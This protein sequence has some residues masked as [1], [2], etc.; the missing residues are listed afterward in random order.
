M[1]L[2]PQ[3]TVRQ[4]L[5][6]TATVGVLVL[7]HSWLLAHAWGQVTPAAADAELRSGRGDPACMGSMQAPST[8]LLLL[9]GPNPSSVALGIHSHDCCSA[10]APECQQHSM[11]LGCLWIHG[12]PEGQRAI[13]AHHLV[14]DAVLHVWLQVGPRAAAWLLAYRDIWCCSLSWPGACLPL[15][16]SP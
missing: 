9:L 13:R 15:R 1:Q 6:V 5:T 14:H 8:A 4:P 3:Q 7:A 10:H 12:E 11:L 2:S 16:H